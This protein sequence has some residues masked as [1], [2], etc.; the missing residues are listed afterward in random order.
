MYF[1]D[2]CRKK[3]NKLLQTPKEDGMEQVCPHCKSEKLKLLSNLSVSERIRFLREN[4]LEKI[5]EEKNNIIIK[6]I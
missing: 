1:C 2:N 5:L 6:K 3:F 4:K